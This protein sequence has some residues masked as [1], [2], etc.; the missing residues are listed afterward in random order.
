VF[1]VFRLVSLDVDGVI[2][3]PDMG[4]R[5]PALFLRWTVG[6]FDSQVASRGLKVKSG[7]K[8]GWDLRRRRLL[9]MKARAGWNGRRWRL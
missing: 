6:S 3:A 2:L 7:V 1:L 9:V 4:M 5:L 8:V